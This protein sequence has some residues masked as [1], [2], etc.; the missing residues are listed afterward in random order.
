MTKLDIVCAENTGIGIPENNVAIAFPCPGM[1]L[2]IAPAVVVCLQDMKA[3]QSLKTAFAV[4]LRSYW[5][6]EVGFLA[7][8]WIISNNKPTGS[9]VQV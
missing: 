4:D 6:C 2:R 8:S 7:P 3:S 1:S 5:R 9:L